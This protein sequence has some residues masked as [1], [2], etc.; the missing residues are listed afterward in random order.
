MRRITLFIILITTTAIAQ[1]YD[2][3]LINE[4]KVHKGNTIHSVAY[5]PDGKWLATGGDDYT[6]RIYST[7]TWELV[8]T[9][10]GHSYWVFSVCFSPDGSTLASGSW[11]EIKLWR[12]SDGSEIRKIKGHSSH[13]FSVCF[14]PDGSMLASGSQDK[15][16]KLW[17]VSDWSK[18][19]IIKGHLSFIN[20]VCFSP[21]GSTLASGNTDNSVKLWRVSDGKLIATLEG[22][23]NSRFRSVNFSADGSMLA[24]SGLDGIKLWEINPPMGEVKFVLNDNTFSPDTVVIH[25]IVRDTVIRY[26][27][28]PEPVDHNPPYLILNTDSIQEL[29]TIFNPLSQCNSSSDSKAVSL[30]D[31]VYAERVERD[32]PKYNL[33]PRKEVKPDTTIIITGG[34]P[35]TTLD[36]DMCI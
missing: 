16:I 15:S 31:S 12:V 13:V 34:N 11:K 1:D 26:A 5:S 21:D 28:K 22:D 25:Q 27:E 20:S 17:R 36:C 2:I 29:I 3:Y 35:A 10:K 9:L 24:A 33:L 6:I 32:D 23:V 18:I 8:H 19:R 30:I 14:S 4:W 7:D